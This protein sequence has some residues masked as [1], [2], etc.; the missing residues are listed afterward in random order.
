LEVPPAV[1]PA[2]APS[3]A[4]QWRLSSRAALP[5]SGQ[6][7]DLAWSRRHLR[8]PSARPRPATEGSP[9]LR[10]RG[11]WPRRPVPLVCV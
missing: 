11:R 9:V 5:G 4:P 6:R 1:L 3:G 8:R 2:G 7:V 10:R